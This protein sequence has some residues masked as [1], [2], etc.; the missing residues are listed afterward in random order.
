MTTATPRAS[1]QGIFATIANLPV[2]NVVWSPQKEPSVLKP[3]TS[4]AITG[5]SNAS[6]IVITA[7]SSGLIFPVGMSVTV[8][9]VGGNSGANGTFP[10]A[11][12]IDAN[13]VSLSG[14]TGTGAFTS[15]GTIAPASPFRWGLLRMKA[16]NRAAQGWDD[17]RRTDNG[18]GTYSQQTVGRRVITIAMDYFSYESADS[19]MS[20]DVLENVRTTLWDPY[21]LNAFNLVGMAV[22]DIG[23]ITPLPQSYNGREISAAHLEITMALATTATA[24]DVFTSEWIKEVAGAGTLTK[25][26][27]T[28][29]NVPLDVVANS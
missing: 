19:I 5:A 18:D 2:A 4:L 11:A 27:G 23:N 12:I 17:L 14:S 3:P 16:M 26:D 24:R 25:E 28:T 9:G 20:D 8:V 29:L 7:A 6:P 21:F 15:G 22:Q 13:N 10:V 1:L